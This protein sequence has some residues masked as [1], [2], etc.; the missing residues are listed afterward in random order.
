MHVI[1]LLNNMIFLFVISFWSCGA[2]SMQA[3]EFAVTIEMLAY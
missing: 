2:S 3:S 1:N